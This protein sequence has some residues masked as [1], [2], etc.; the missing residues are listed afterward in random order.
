MYDQL[1]ALLFYHLK[2]IMQSLC[3]LS[4]TCSSSPSPI[5]SPMN[6]RKL[7]NGGKGGE[8]ERKR[9]KP[10]AID[11]SVLLAPNPSGGKVRSLTNEGGR[12]RQ[13]LENGRDFKV[14]PHT[15]WNALQQW[16]GVGVALPRQVRVI[17]F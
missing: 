6:L 14:L 13:N 10:G 4:S 15:L 8:K 1:I 5:G 9:R 11:N 3:V 12:L 7:P 17:C 2:T 16:Y